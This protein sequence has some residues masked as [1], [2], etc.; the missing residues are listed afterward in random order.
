MLSA[1]QVARA[2]LWGGAARRVPVRSENRVEAL[3]ENRAIL[4]ERLAERALEARAEL[5]EGIPRSAVL[6]RDARLDAVQTQRSK[7]IFQQQP[8]RLDVHAGSP[9]LPPDPGANLCGAHHRIEV[10]ESHYAQR[11]VC[12]AVGDGEDVLSVGGAKRFRTCNE[13][14][15]LTDRPRRIE[16]EKARHLG[17]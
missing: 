8:L 2:A 13:T 1:F 7:R 10:P 15:R 3:V 9:A 11:V 16:R 14:Q 12:E 4:P 5:H 17:V 6:Q